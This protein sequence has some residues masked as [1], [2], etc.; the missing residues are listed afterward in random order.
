MPYRIIST[1]PQRGQKSV[2]VTAPLIHNNQLCATARVSGRS[3]PPRSDIYLTSSRSVLC[4][5]A[6]LCWAATLLAPSQIV[7]QL[8]GMPAQP[9][10]TLHTGD[11]VRISVWQRPEL[12]GEFPIGDDGSIVHPLYR[13]LQVSGIPLSD[14]EERVRSFLLQ[15]DATP[16]FVIEPLLQITLAGQIA[17]PNVYTLPPR[18]TIAQAIAVAGGPTD[19]GRLTAVQLVREGRAFSVDLTR[20]DATLAR[21]PIRSGDQIMIFPTR[22]VWREVVMPSMSVIGAVAGVISVIMRARR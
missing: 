19:R 9:A 17:R 6:L 11:A 22:S 3:T 5:L 13:A 4:F 14:V 2:C 1:L 10:L 20:P 7:A 15:F 12:S 8:A 21:M 18:T 16:T